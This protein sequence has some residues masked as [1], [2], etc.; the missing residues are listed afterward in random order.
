LYPNAIINTCNTCGHV[1]NQLSDQELQ[2]LQKYYNEEYA[3]VNLAATDNAGDRPGSTSPFSTARYEQLYDLIIPFISAESRVLDVGCAMGGYLNY[4]Y[5]EGFRN[6]FGIDMTKKYVEYASNQDKYTIRLGNAEWI[7]FNANFFDCLVIDQVMEHLIEPNKAFKEAR[8]VLREGGFFCIA[9]PDASRYAKKYFFDFYW[10]IMREHIQ[11]FDIT[12]LEM[13]AEKEGFELITKSKNESPMMSENMILPNLNAIFKLSNNVRKRKATHNP[14]TLQRK[15]KKYIAG[16]NKRLI[17]K[18]KIIEQLKQSQKSLYV[19]G[20]GREFLYLYEE[21]GLKHCNIEALID[22][23]PYKQV[24]AT[25]DGKPVMGPS[26]LEKAARD[27]ALLITAFAHQNA[28]RKALDNMV[29]R[30]NIIV[31][32]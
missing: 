27:S 30:G 2:G 15:I 28:I 20:I 7:P 32:D 18:R 11:H 21:A 3:P 17:Y 25:I 8:R 19:W 13:L 6:L 16:E 14:F 5:R 1:Y 24:Q 9:V 10:F 4:L 29:Y 26:V 31:F 22:V 23:N 12:H